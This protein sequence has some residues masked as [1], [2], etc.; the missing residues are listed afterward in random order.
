MNGARLTN[1]IQYG[2]QYPNS[3][4]D[5]YIAD[6]DPTVVRPTYLFFTGNPISAHRPTAP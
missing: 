5:V 6:N 3:Y 4:L 1:D 2:T